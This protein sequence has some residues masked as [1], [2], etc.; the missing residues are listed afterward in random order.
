MEDE[1]NFVG[2]A[3]IPLNFLDPTMAKAWGMKWDQAIILELKF[4][5]E[6]YNDQVYSEEKF[7]EV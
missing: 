4:N 7:G 2:R 6:N 1:D 3:S 5:L